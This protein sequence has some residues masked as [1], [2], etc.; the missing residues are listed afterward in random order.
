MNKLSDAMFSRG[1]FILGDEGEKIEI[2]GASLECDFKDDTDIGLS[3]SVPKSF[4]I[5][6]DNCKLNR[7]TWLSLIYGVRIS[8]NW[9][10][11]HGG[12]MSRKIYRKKGFNI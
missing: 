4:E 8:N 5:T 3:I 11:L 7:N 12:V 1:I 10:K 2:S 9:L 6:I